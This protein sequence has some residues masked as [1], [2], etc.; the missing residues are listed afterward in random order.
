MRRLFIILACLLLSLTA[1]SQKFIIPFSSKKTPREVG[2][3]GGGIKPPTI[4][5][6]VGPGKEGKGVDNVK[7]QAISPPKNPDVTTG[8]QVEGIER[9]MTSVD[10]LERLAQ[11]GNVDAHTQL[12]MYYFHRNDKRAMPHL[13]AGADA[14]DRLAQYYL[15]GAYYKGMCGAKTDK[16]TAAS[17]FLKS[18]RQNH[19]P[20]QYAIAVCLYN[21][22]GTKEDKNAAREWM[23]K[24]AESGNDDAKSFL[25]SH[26]FE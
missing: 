26:S 21:G 19:V 3:K 9:S 11:K 22:E 24:A 10:D 8:R 1:S 6:T 25:Q 15:G 4:T 5:S 14:G 23:K 20:A 17:Y 16:A 7:S 12:G 13:R 2:Q 18:A